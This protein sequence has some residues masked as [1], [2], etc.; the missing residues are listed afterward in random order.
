MKRDSDKMRTR[1]SGR[2]FQWKEMEVPSA[3]FGSSRQKCV[4]LVNIEIGE[5]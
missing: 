3:Q 2:L 4:P 1:M 5:I